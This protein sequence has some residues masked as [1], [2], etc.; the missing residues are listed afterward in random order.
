MKLLLLISVGLFLS[1][2]FVGANS[3]F[4]K[5]IYQWSQVRYENYLLFNAQEY[6]G[7]YPYYIPENNALMGLSHHAASG[8]TIVTVPR[9]RPGI[10][11]TLNAFCISDYKQGKSPYLW[12][13]PY[14]ERNAIKPIFYEF[15]NQ[16]VAENFSIISVFSPS[17]H[18]SCDRFYAVDTGVLEYGPKG[19]YQVQKPAILV[20]QLA[21][22]SCK[23]RS[24]PLIRRVEIPD[25]VYNNPTG[26]MHMS[27]D[28]V[29]GGTCDDVMISLAN[30]FDNS[31]VMFEY[32]T[33][34]FWNATDPRMAPIQA[35]SKVKLQGEYYNFPLGISVTNQA[36]ADSDGNAEVYYTSTASFGMYSISTRYLWDFATVYNT[37]LST[38][39][40]DRGCYSQS[41]FQNLNSATNVMFIQQMNAN[42][43]RCWNINKL[44]SVDTVGLIFKGHN[45]SL[46]TDIA[47]DADGYMYIITSPFFINYVTK[48][49]V[50]I[51]NVNTRIY[52][53]K[54]TDVIRGT[55]CE[56]P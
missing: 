52:R 53:A 22:D 8:L 27:V 23:T 7:K 47:S 15:F 28:E 10:P 44:L 37:S 34:Q 40:G 54:Y 56:S 51:N 9:V 2:S 19:Y 36:D 4:I 14:Y 49:T 43:V 42:E 30:S 16:N 13:F 31:I 41:Y 11:S 50:N 29:S 12:S 3:P 6:I 39:Y 17:I 45:D 25:T 5:E 48:K 33:G 26:F 18:R 32:A 21:A 1:Y 35:L 55:V 46:V 20:Y 38:V 24:F